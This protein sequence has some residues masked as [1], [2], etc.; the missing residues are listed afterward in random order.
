MQDHY[1]STEQ[2]ERH[3][4]EEHGIRRCGTG[5]GEKPASKAD[6]G[7]HHDAEPELEVGDLFPEVIEF[8]HK[9]LCMNVVRVATLTAPMRD[10]I[11]QP[12]GA[13]AAAARRSASRSGDSRPP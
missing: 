8:R 9:A 13:A 2:D 7:D 4:S 10:E 3:D 12:R 1:I 11:Q 6:I 5:R